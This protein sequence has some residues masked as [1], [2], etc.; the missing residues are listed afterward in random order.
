MTARRTFLGFAALAPL[1]T[2]SPFARAQGYPAKPVR[3][4]VG[5]AAGGNFDIVA[6]LMAPWLAQRLGQP[7]VVENRP[8]A[9]SNLAAEAV[10]RAPPDG[11]TLL[12]GGAANSVNAALRDDL[13][14]DFVKDAAPIAGLVRFANIMTVAPS[15]PARTV[16]EFIAYTRANPGKVNHGSSGNGTTQHLAGEL[17]KRMTGADFVHVPYKGASEAI[18]ALLGGQVQVIFEPL[19]PSLGQIRAGKLKALAVTTASRAETLPDVP[20]MAEL[21]P[22]YEASGWIALFAPRGTPPEAIA[23]LND[24]VTSGLADPALKARLTDIGAAP[25]P[26]SPAALGD[27]VREETLKWRRLGQAAGI[28]AD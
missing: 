17:F 28:R 15:F 20:A 9:G 8:G 18:N 13:P 27:F 5:F 1:A 12:V 25:F 14:F 3:L 22:G 23:R 16:Q 2:L 11:Y 19:P 7:V 26:T 4:V 24:A 6:R 21:V 10:L